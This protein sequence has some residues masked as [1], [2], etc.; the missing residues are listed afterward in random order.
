MIRPSVVR[1]PRWIAAVALMG[2]AVLLTGI[3]VR[4]QT[5]V[6]VDS[7]ASAGFEARLDSL[8]AAGHRDR[9]LALVEDRL[10]DHP[11]DYR[12]HVLAARDAFWL[13]YIAMYRQRDEDAKAWF[14]RGAGEADWALGVRP[15]DGEARYLKLAANGLRG[16]LEGGRESA[17]LAA[18]VDTAAR[19]LIAADSTNAG[20]YNALGRLY[21]RVAGLSWVERAIGGRW[22]G[23]D[24]RARSTWEAA[25]ANLR[26]AT[27]LAPE[28]NV[29]HLD[30]G[31]FYV[32]LGRL[33]EAR[34]A[35]EAAVA[36]PLQVPEEELA[37]DHARRLLEEIAGR[38]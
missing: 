1:V 5:P 28:V 17:R 6:S 15:L 2:V 12:A 13:G 30:L 38:L 22:V 4:A 8:V 34:A 16:V 24:L 19:S 33:T 18:V 14:L 32:R 36:A 11:D 31:V 23:S 35:L 29:F 26:R 7:S 9:S 10:T 37:R 3:Q 21:E 25:E 27:E 20:A